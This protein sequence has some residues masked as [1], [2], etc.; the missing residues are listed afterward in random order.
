MIEQIIEGHWNELTGRNKTMSETRLQIC[1]KC[2]LYSPKLGGVCN[3]KLWVDTQTGDIS[4]TKKDGY[5]NGCG[6]RV[7]AKTTLPN[8]QCPL[9]KW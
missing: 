2:S 3:K 7:Q 1:Y 5:V 4:I 8:A 6:C 9:N